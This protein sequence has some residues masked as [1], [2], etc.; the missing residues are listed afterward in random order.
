MLMGITTCLCFRPNSSSVVKLIFWEGSTRVLTEKKLAG[1]IMFEFPDHMV[2]HADS[3]FIGRPIP[4]LSIDDELI[5]NQTYFVLPLDSFPTNVLSASSLSSLVS[6]PKRC[7]ID[8]KHRPFEYI[9]GSNGRVSIRVLP[10]FLTQVM[11]RGKGLS[12]DGKDSNGTPNS[13]G[14]LCST[15]ELKK[16]YDQLVGSK[17]Q[18]WSPKL[19]TISEYKVRVS[20]CWFLGLERKQKEC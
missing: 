19:E 12:E 8:F 16:H 10:E 1:E 9:K 14:F 5:K 13:H 17:D 3:F 20:P 18:V 11:T 4:S 15:P 2:C 6:S 7:P